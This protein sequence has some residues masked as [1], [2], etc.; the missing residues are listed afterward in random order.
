MVIRI[1]VR[2][3]VFETVEEYERLL[4]LAVDEAMRG[5]IADNVKRAIADAVESH[6]YSYEPE[7]LSRQ[8]YNGGLQDPWYMND[9][10]DAGSN[11]LTVKMETP[12]QHLYGGNYPGSDLADVVEQNGMYGAGP[13]E[14]MQPAE[15]DYASSQFESDLIM[16]LHESGLY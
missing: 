14:F 10:Y 11:T 7:F 16:A 1:R 8:G 5:F 13:R 12:W 4:D 6:V 3:M 9:T 2:S 15:Q